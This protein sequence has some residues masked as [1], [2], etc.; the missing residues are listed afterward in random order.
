MKKTVLVALFSLLMSASSIAGHGVERGFVKIDDGG[1]LETNISKFLSKKLKSCSLGLSSEVFTVESVQ[2]T[3]DR[4]DNGITDLY[5]E[6]SL[7]YDAERNDIIK[8][9][10]TVKIVDSAF[11]NWS[12]Y[13]EKLTSEISFDRNGFCKN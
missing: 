6:V 1:K 3:E 4:V 2:V 11:H 10:I 12:D 5:Y 13:E 7:S 8:N 9:D